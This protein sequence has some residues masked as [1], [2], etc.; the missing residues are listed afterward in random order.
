MSFRTSHVRETYLKFSKLGLGKAMIV[1]F[2]SYLEVN[3]RSY[4][5]RTEN[6]MPV[7]INRKQPSKM[8]INKKI[9]FF[10]TK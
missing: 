3:F 10:L 9:F 7:H 8:C 2:L 4:S 6:D 1:P 5:L